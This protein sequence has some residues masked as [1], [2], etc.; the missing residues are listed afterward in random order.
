M[1][2]R[3][4]PAFA[5]T[6]ARPARARPNTPTPGVREIE[7]KLEVDPGSGQVSAADIIGERGKTDHLLTTYFDTPD[8][9]VRKAGCSLR[10]RHAHGAH[11]QT[12]K[13][14]RGFASGLFNRTE[15]T[16]AIA[17]DRP[18]LDAS[19]GP[20]GP[21]LRG[22]GLKR[23]EPRVVTDFHRTHGLI[24]REDGKIE[25][26][27]DEGRISAGD[28]VVPLREIELELRDGSAKV[29]FD[30][31]REIARQVPVRIAVLSKSQR[32]YRLLE[33][34]APTPARAEPILLDRRDSAREAFAIIAH[35]CL[36]QFRINE[37]LIIES[38]DAEAV[39]QARVALRRLR[40]A[41]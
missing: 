3:A 8:G 32:G 19:S 20:F 15:W 22:I 28:L 10:I 41:F 37:A 12:I 5:H 16:R 13:T 21:T 36:R 23:L 1:P 29:L 40:T 31:A 6:H 11:M 35:S 7:L 2:S 17:G 24:D 4:A 39:H 27:I 26:A 9:E 18:V 38:G 30:I 14:T 25:W 34:A 33:G